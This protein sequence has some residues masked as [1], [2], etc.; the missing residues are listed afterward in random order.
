MVYHTS[1]PRLARLA[2][3]LA[4]VS[5][6]AEQAQGP[7]AIPDVMVARYWKARAD[8]AQALQQMVA[9]CHGDVG[10]A[11]NGDPACAPHETEK[12]SGK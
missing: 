5:L 1:M 4:A 2:L 11:P 10:L 8:L 7:M 3:F 6:G 12:E 9:F